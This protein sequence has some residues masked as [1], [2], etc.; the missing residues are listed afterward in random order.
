MLRRLVPTVLLLLSAASL[1]R[2]SDLL[3]TMCNFKYFPGAVNL[4]ESARSQG[5]WHQ[6][7]AVLVTDDV[8]ACARHIFE[9]M[10]VQV[11]NISNQWVGKRYPSHA[12][13]WITTVHF[14][15]LD[16][17]SQEYFRQFERIIYADSDMKARQPLEELMRAVESS[18][19]AYVRVGNPEA[20]LYREAN[21][22]VPAEVRSRF[23]DRPKVHS[24][25]LMVFNMHLLESSDDMTATLTGLLS[26]VGGS[27]NKMYEQG[28]LQLLFYTTLADLPA[29]QVAGLLEHYYSSAL[30]WNPKHQS[31]GRF[32]LWFEAQTHDSTCFKEAVFQ[33]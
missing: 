8:P 32:A 30:P 18:P 7:L 24:T 10:H 14:G 22:P 2:S 29:A 13:D 16:I 25:R 28:V 11:I 21:L 12:G 27:F 5:N 31:F 6:E 33:R 23:P 17:L 26:T 15:K 19:A 3:V 20:T 4:L 9:A 1:S